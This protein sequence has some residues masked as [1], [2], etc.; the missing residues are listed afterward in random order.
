M[1]APGPLSAAL[2]DL[3]HDALNARDH[4]PDAYEAVFE[5]LLMSDREGGLEAFWVFRSRAETQAALEAA[6]PAGEWLASAWWP[7]VQA[8]LRTIGQQWW[9]QAEASVLGAVASPGSGRRAARI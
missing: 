7:V 5:P 2:E 9:A 4:G 3:L 6:M 8:N 1:D